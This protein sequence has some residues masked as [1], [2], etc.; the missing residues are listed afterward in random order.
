MTLP[1][2]WKLVPIG[3]L[4]KRRLEQTQPS[5]RP[6]HIFNFVGLE[7][8]E[9]RGTGVVHPR[10]LMGAEIR[11]AKFAF[12]PG[13]VLFGKLRAYLN[14]VCVANEAGVCSTD[15]WVLSPTRWIL[16]EFAFAALSSP[17]FIRRAE[18][19]TQGG[20]L[21]RLDAGSFDSFEI[22]LPPIKEQERIVAILRE[23]AE[24]RS[25]GTQVRD[26]AQQLIPS[27]FNEMFGSGHQGSKQ[28]LDQFAEVVSGVAKGRNVM[29]GNREVPYLRVANVQAGRL[30][31]SEIKMIPATDS[32]IEDLRLQPGDVL[33][34]EG[35][36]FDKL[37]RGA[38][39]RG[40]IQDCIH[41]N[42]IFRVR[43]HAGKLDPVFLSAFLQSAAGRRFFLRAAK[44]TTNLASINMSQLRALPLPVIPFPQQIRF[45]KRVEAFD[46]VM[47]EN[48]GL[49]SCNE[50]LAASLNAYA[51]TGELTARWR[52][53]Y[54]SELA[55]QARERDTA[56]RALGSKL[57]TVPTETIAERE[58]RSGARKEGAFAELTAQQE[59]LLEALESL[60]LRTAQES[61]SS[62]GANPRAHA[63][64][65]P[66]SLAPEAPN[67]LRHQPDLIRRELEVLATRGL[68]L[69]VSRRS[70]REAYEP[71][72]FA[73]L[74]RLPASLLHTKDFKVEPGGMVQE[75]NIR[76]N[77][78]L[79]LATKLGG[80]API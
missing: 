10:R 37:G 74:Y 26:A 39:W 70:H 18:Q 25:F 62:G 9:G 66:A 42:H 11:S 55:V 77:E 58:S 7:D 19:V 41:Q 76:D 31:L 50:E 40:E 45:R 47:Q 34:T 38:I 4:L 21:P 43:P 27:I 12:E 36:D 32:E 60:A 52:D 72:A 1:D 6:T 56:L 73:D 20:S 79:Q 54:R 51:F 59:A 2:N 15:I 64:F 5:D 14:K 61:V 3:M 46:A 17:W 67:R 24:L 63:V 44:R 16:P 69:R 23:A 57:P 49:D 28:R 68:V 33:L 22:P 53:S 78:L 13:D 29:G 8:I 48:A 80:R 65:T 71:D 35:G 30:D 75:E